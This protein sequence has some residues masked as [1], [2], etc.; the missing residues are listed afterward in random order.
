MTRKVSDYANS[1]IYKICCNDASITDVYVGSTTAF[2]KRK[3][4]HKSRCNNPNNKQYKFHVY[5][6]IRGNG[7]WDNWSMIL[8]ESY[9]AS[10]K[11]ELETRERYWLETLKATLNKQVPTRTQHEYYNYYRKNNRDVI[12]HRQKTYRESNVEQIKLY[13]DE[14]KD[15]KKD[16]DKTYRAKQFARKLHEFI[17]S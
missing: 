8:V 7:G 4:Q 1:S 5:Q 13:R 9:N 14:N 11:R 10:N 17:Y 3:H 2:S 6:F 16:Y 12:K 15:K